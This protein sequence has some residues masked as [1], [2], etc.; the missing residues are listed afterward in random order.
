[1][2]WAYALGITNGVDSTHFDPTGNLNR[3]Q[4]ATFLLR[5]ADAYD[6]KVSKS[7]NQAADYDDIAAK[8]SWA[9]KAVRIFGGSLIDLE[10][11]GMFN[12]TGDATREQMAKAISMF[13]VPEGGFVLPDDNPPAEGGNKVKINGTE[14]E[15]KAGGQDSITLV[16]SYGTAI[17]YGGKKFTKIFSDA[18]ADDAVVT[19]KCADG[20]E[21]PPMTGAQIKEA[22]FVFKVDGVEV[23]DKCKDNGVDYIFRLAV[24]PADGT[25]NGSAAKYVTEITITGTEAPVPAGNVIKINGVDTEVRPSDKFEMTLTNKKGEDVVYKGKTFVKIYTDTIADDAVVTITSADGQQSV[26][27]GGQL[28]LAMFAFYKD[29]EEIADTLDGVTYPMR[30]AYPQADG[31][32]VGAP[33]KFVVAIDF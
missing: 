28:K 7:E 10:E 13:P 24:P 23:L 15:L 11:G 17:E 19:V 4:M 29:G 33:D 2:A 14:Y 26:I 30:F 31:T 18:I 20:Y 8:W 5:F 6:V 27:N 16:N 32:Y 1:M 12:A 9:A 21:I 3:A 22:V 25:N